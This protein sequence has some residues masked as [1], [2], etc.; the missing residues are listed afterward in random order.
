LLKFFFFVFILISV[1]NDTIEED[2]SCSQ[3]ILSLKPIYLDSLIFPKLDSSDVLIQHYAYSMVYDN[4]HEQ[5]KWVCYKI[6]NEFEVGIY[7]RTN[8]FK[9][10]PLVL[11]GS[12]SHSD[13]KG[14]GYDRGHLAP[15]A[16]MTWSEVAMKESFYYSNMSPQTASFN[17]GVWKRLESTV[18]RWGAEF[19]S[20]YVTT[21][22]LLTDSLDVIGSSVSVPNHFYKTVIS[23]KG[24]KPFSSISFLLENKGS[25]SKLE[26]FVISTDSLEKISNIDFNY[27][28]NKQIQD[29][30]EA[31]LD[32]SKWSWP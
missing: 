17:R 16:D 4:S 7:K 2:L 22:P 32:I 25:K 21:G 5:S 8:S 15:A 31:N 1:V 6:S 19:D 24:G 29:S 11:G 20:L 28:L 9:K 23:F 12:A 10:D 27:H 14:S 13:Y 3:R 18:R 26:N 30:L